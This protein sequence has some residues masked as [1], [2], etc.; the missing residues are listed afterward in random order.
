MAPIAVPHWIVANDHGG[1][2]PGSDDHQGPRRLRGTINAN[3]L[4]R[5]FRNY[6]T[7]FF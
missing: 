4:S 5:R 7:T 3:G 2:A 6:L 1:T